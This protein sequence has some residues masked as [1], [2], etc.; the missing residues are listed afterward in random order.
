M[1][2]TI[3]IPNL[4]DMRLYILTRTLNVGI[5]HI[6]SFLEKHPE[7]GEVTNLTSN[8]QLNDKQVAAVV[9]FF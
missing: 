5:N 3:I 7:L 9:D 6:I 4:D 1:Q 8:S 2:C